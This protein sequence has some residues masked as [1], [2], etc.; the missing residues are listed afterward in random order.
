MIPQFDLKKE[1]ALLGNEIQGELKQVFSKTNFIG[2]DNV[3]SIEKNIA[4]YI[5]V[6]YAIS[7]NSG[8]DALHFALKSFGI[9]KGDEVITTP[10]TFIS[11]IEAIMYLGAKPIFVD[12]D[13]KSYNINENEILKKITNKT[14]AILPVHLFGNPINVN[15]IKDKINNNSIKIIEDC[16][17]SFGSG[18]NCQRVGSI[19]DIGCFSFYPTKNLGC[20][21]DGGMVTTNSQESYETILK[22]RNHG[23]SKRYHHDII[24][25]NSRLDEIQAAILNVKLKYIDQFNLMRAKLASIYNDNLKGH[26]EIMLPNKNKNAFHVY[27]QY[28]INS[29]NRNK[30]KEELEKNNIGS[31]IYYPISLEKQKAYKDVYKDTVECINSNYLSNTCLSLPMYPQ[32]SEENVIKV[33]EVIKQIK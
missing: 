4:N 25:Y 9:G 19:G 18:I 31:A 30:I 7:C 6:K 11:T 12:I 26:K 23:S 13:L 24:G 5:G 27:H 3:R 10:F 29:K 33:C 32:L 20:Y 8:T 22:L 17:Q 28:T 2:G 16:A 14:K 1:Y 15:N 21:G